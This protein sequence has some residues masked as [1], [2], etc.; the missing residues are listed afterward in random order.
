MNEILLFLVE[1]EKPIQENTTNIGCSQ[2]QLTASFLGYLVLFITIIYL[3]VY[4]Y[5]LLKLYIQQYNFK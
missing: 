2:E 1:K 3:T 5:G 4:L